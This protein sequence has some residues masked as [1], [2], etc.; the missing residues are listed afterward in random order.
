MKTIFTLAVMLLVGCNATNTTR[1]M[2]ANDVQQ[3]ADELQV[4]QNILY[5]DTVEKVSYP[6]LS[7]G[8]RGELARQLDLEINDSVQII[9]VREVDQTHILAAYKIGLDTDPDH[10]K[11]YFVTHG[12]GGAVIDALD[13]GEFHI[14][15]PQKP[16][17]FG[18]N[19]SYTLDSS[20]TFDGGNHF[21]VHRV[22]AL[23]SIYLKDRTLTQMWRVEW[24][25]DYEISKDA[26]FVF[27]GQ[28]ETYR[29]EG[30]E[31]PVIDEFK[32]R[33]R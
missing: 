10:F 26:R 31:D 20:V 14:C 2:N 15:E 18:G 23:T 29:S 12:K 27:M 24:D 3:L 13:L 1:M 32:S 21:T 33:L 4:G 25:D 7:D 30:L 6:L 8:E 16:M 5:R 28:R 22:L 9:G 17:R 19:R 11:V